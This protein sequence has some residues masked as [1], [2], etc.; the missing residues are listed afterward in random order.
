MTTGQP[1]EILIMDSANIS[2]AQNILR[3]NMNGLGLST[4]GGSTYE[5][6]ITGAGIVANAIVA[7]QLIAANGIYA[8]DMSTG[9]VN[10][11]N[12]NITGGSI[13][14]ETASETDDKII[15][16][17]NRAYSGSTVYNSVKTA[18]YGIEINRGA[19]DANDNLLWDSLNKLQAAGITMTHTGASGSQSEINLSP[20]T[21]LSYA[22]YDA[23]NNKTNET[24][25]R[26]DR[27]SISDFT[28]GYYVTLSPS[29][30]LEFTND[31]GQGRTYPAV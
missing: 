9:T 7:G 18:P 6:A 30:G 1:Y 26:P 12:A 17:Y 10:M 25:I 3:L 11:A 14:I 31:H 21:S 20:S 29:G 15:L 16:R 23:N 24:V 22:Y 19:K 27:I 2:T 4:D 13:N 8:L 28:N 5:V